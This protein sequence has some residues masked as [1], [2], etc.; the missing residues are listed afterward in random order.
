MLTL[1]DFF[2][3]EAS[4]YAPKTLKNI[5]KCFSLLKKDPHNKKIHEKLIA[6]IKVFTKIKN[7]SLII[8][9]DYNAM[10][11]PVF[12]KG[13]F[14]DI[15]EL[16]KNSFES[17]LDKVDINDL[18]K[19]KVVVEPSTGIKKIYLWF[20]VQL[21]N[22]M[23]PNQL[24][25]ILLHELGHVYYMFSS[26]PHFAERLI[27]AALSLVNR[28]IIVRTVVLSLVGVISVSITK[29][30]F[31]AFLV[32]TFFIHCIGFRERTDEYR[33]D[34]FAL[35]Y[36]YGDDLASAFL[37]FEKMSRELSPLA[38]T[39]IYIK[40]INMIFGIFKLMINSPTHPSNKDR[41]Q[42]LEE[43][44]FTEYKKMYPKYKSL[45]KKI[46]ED[47]SEQ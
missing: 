22:D 1:H 45:I 30:L 14:D 47:Y 21:I 36:G 7:V 35:K 25:A 43:Q 23:T 46:E 44:I 41:L 4:Q 33:S 3:Y 2:I 40:F 42:S 10:T 6:E 34:N 17:K 37:K 31:L 5:S 18:K 8:I 29:I 11:V 15:T 32:S 38:S 27:K 19:L 20:G 9:N 24:T 16:I 28:V 13:P 12:N 39:S 26:F